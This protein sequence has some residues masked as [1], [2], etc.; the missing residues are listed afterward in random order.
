MTSKNIGKIKAIWMLGISR[1][2]LLQI[3]AKR[4]VS[5]SIGRCWSVHFRSFELPGRRGPPTTPGRPRLPVAPTGAHCIVTEVVNGPS[6]KLV[7]CKT[8][9]LTKIA[10]RRNLFSIS[11]ID[12]SNELNVLEEVSDVSL[13]DN[14]EID[15]SYVPRAA[16][17]QESLKIT[18]K[19]V[20]DSTGTDN[21]TWLAVPSTSSQSSLVTSDNFA[22]EEICSTRQGSSTDNE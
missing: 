1:T 18:F 4:I 6:V 20:E 2:N 16:S 14:K 12:I 21:M 19:Q 7:D 3:L 8:R 22:D 11:G 5:V 9:Y 17:T 15:P 10:A 13:S